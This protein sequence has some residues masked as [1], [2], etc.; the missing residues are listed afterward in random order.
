VKAQTCAS[1][2]VRSGAMK[3]PA[4]RIEYAAEAEE[5]LEALGARDAV[6]ALDTVPRQLAHEP[7]VRTRNRKPLE[8]NPVAPWELRIGHL[9]VY[10]DVEEEPERIVRVRAVGRKDR[11][12]VLIGGEEVELR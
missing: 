10:F 3:R 2:D 6:T 5:H 7:L 9:R 8:A 1:T 4:Y 11:D 12:R